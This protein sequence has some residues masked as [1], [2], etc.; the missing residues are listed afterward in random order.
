[1]ILLDKNLLREVLAGAL[2]GGGDFA[3]IYVEYKRV[4]GIGCEDGKIERIHSGIEAGA[5]IRV[6]SGDKTAYAYTNDL[7]REGLLEAAR[8]V[9]H[10]V[11]GEKKEAGVE[12][13]EKKPA[14]KF[15]IIQMPDKVTT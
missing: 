4:T 8:I 2:A 9:S 1:V 6:L 13:R 14:V 5:G 12:F 3:D 15:E 11:S 10:A 7:S